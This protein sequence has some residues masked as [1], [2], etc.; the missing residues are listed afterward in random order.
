MKNKNWSTFIDLSLGKHRSLAYRVHR[1]TGRRSIER[2]SANGSAV[3]DR[4]VELVSD[5][6]KARTRRHSRPSH[7][8][9]AYYQEAYTV[10]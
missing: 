9:I 7:Y 10:V 3:V 5:W 1:F 6:D 2:T 8:G 4:N